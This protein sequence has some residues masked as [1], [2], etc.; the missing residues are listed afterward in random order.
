VEVL[1]VATLCPYV[2]ERYFAEVN[3]NAVAY[4]QTD[5]GSQGTQMCKQH[6]RK[7]DRFRRDR[8]DEEERI[9]CD[10]D[11]LTIWEP[12]QA[13]SHGSLMAGQKCFSC[14]L[15]EALLERSGV[16]QI[17]EQKRDQTSGVLLTKSQEPLGFARCQFLRHTSTPNV[18]RGLGGNLYPGR[19]V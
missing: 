6:K 17:R 12:L 19:P 3:P 5:L 2:G 13:I 18:I 10:A 8:K 11:F 1:A 16:D 14:V 4:R 15:S 7:R 9:T